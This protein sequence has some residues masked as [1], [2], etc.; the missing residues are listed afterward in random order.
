MQYKIAK[1]IMIDQRKLE[2]LFRLGCPDQQ[3]IELLKTGTFTPTGDPLMDETLESLIDYK[4]FDNWGGA[5]DGAG[6]K[7]KE[8]AK[9]NQVE[10]QDEIQDGI[11]DGNQ[12]AFQVVDKDID[13]INNSR[14]SISNLD[15][16]R[17]KQDLD[18]P[19][20]YQD[21]KNYLASQIS[22]KLG[23]TVPT[24]GWLDDIRKLCEIDHA[25]PKHVLD[26]L[27][28]HFDNYDREYRLE[29]QSAKT[30][31]EKFTRLD[32]AYQAAS[33]QDDEPFYL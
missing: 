3:I 6:R 10:N 21:I 30:L 27:R 17:V 25:D 12:D 29:I 19:T 22:Q 26:A 4:A 33:K 16:T 1:K 15:T 31:R 24:R 20:E 13:I 9:N 18:Y 8:S 11:Q 28:W 14:N 2:M 5:R 7:P 23:R 32:M